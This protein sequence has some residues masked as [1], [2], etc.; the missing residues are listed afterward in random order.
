MEGV[1][2][3]RPAA[4]FPGVPALST[5]RTRTADLRNIVPEVKALM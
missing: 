2:S 4:A 3:K 5:N 1:N